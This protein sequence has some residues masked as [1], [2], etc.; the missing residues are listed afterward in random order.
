MQPGFAQT[1]GTNA[2]V[3]RA[4]A[5]AF[6]WCLY[7][8]RRCSWCT[9]FC[10]FQMGHAMVQRSDLSCRRLHRQSLR[11]LFMA[12]DPWQVF[13]KGFVVWTRCRNIT[14]RK[15]C[16]AGCRQPANPMVYLCSVPLTSR[17]AWRTTIGHNWGGFE[18]MSACRCTPATCQRLP[19]QV[20]PSVGHQK[21][22]GQQKCWG[23]PK[24]FRNGCFDKVHYRDCL[25]LHELLMHACA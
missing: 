19:G 24:R 1:L 16:F 5:L 18:P 17:L 12:S 25:Q 4:D 20:H 10:V 2:G 6:L 11:H 15:C 23:S 14:S 22:R 8:L 3:A 13:L 21:W 9:W 7:R